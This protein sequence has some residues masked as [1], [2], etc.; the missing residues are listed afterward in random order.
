MRSSSADSVGSID[1][2][3]YLPYLFQLFIARGGQYW[4][5]EVPSLHAL[6]ENPPQPPSS[7]GPPAAVVNCT[8]LGS[9]TLGDVKD[10]T[11][12]PT[13]GQTVLIRA[14]WLKRG[15]T[16]VPAP[17]GT[18]VAYIIPRQSG[19][20]I[21][22]GT[23]DANDWEAKPREETA[24]AIM[25]RC[26]ALTTDLL[27][28]HKRENGTID[29]LEVIEYGAGLRPT[30]QGGV[31]LDTTYLELSG[32]RRV[33]IVSNYGHG[34]AGYQSSWGSAE[35]AVMLLSDAVPLARL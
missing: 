21:L 23:L 30:R 31:R 35:R 10:E 17:D 33:P 2:P 15:L 6:L 3:R 34:G 11:V 5:A 14:P 18:A 24:R 20:V 12:F 8:G 1:T 16:A 26:L 27:P 25:K 4:R 9:R 7:Y 13:R 29:D 22:G 19:A 28:P 32:G